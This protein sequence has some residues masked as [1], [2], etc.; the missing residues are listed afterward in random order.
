MRMHM[1]TKITLT[2]ICSFCICTCAFFYATFDRGGNIDYSAVAASQNTVDVQCIIDR[3][4]LNTYS[5]I[6]PEFERSDYM[7]VDAKEQAYAMEFCKL[8]AK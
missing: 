5:I 1:L 7:S 6:M 2:V 8:M 4:T 3:Y